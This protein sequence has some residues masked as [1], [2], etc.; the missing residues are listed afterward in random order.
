VLIGIGVV[1]WIIILA[2]IQDGLKQL[3]AEKNA[4]SKG[5]A[6]SVPKTP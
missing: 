2:L 5:E 6:A 1:A 4:T 3:R